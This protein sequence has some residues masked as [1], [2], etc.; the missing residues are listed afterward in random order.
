MEQKLKWL[1]ETCTTC[2]HQM[3]SWDMRLTKCFKVR[4]TCEACFCEIYDLSEDAFRKT[5]EDYFGLR[6]CQGI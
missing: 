4:H 1:D 6:P 5:M 3:N 2:G